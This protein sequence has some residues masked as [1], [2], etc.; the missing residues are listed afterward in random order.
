MVRKPPTV[1]VKEKKE[2][3]S[4]QATEEA[5]EGLCLLQLL[6]F[7]A[8]LVVVDGLVELAVVDNSSCG[9]YFSCRVLLL[10][11]TL[12]SAL[13]VLVGAACL[14]LLCLN[15]RELLSLLLLVV[16]GIW[17]WDYCVFE[18]QLLSCVSTGSWF[19]ACYNVC[20]LEV[21]VWDLRFGVSSLLAEVVL[22]A[23]VGRSCFL[24]AFAWD[25][26]MWLWWFLACLCVCSTP[27]WNDY[28]CCSIKH[29]LGEHLGHLLEIPA[30][31]PKVIS[32]KKCW[33]PKGKSPL[34]TGALFLG[35]QGGLTWPWKNPFRTFH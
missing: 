5:A 32:H 8:A 15:K 9:W 31:A 4:I 29:L 21:G 26:L 34:P 24:Y 19:F 18:F 3:S 14:E 16:C 20:C 22:H 11:F 30:R 17:C 13:L 6:L 28:Q 23:Y 2:P 7:F 10:L 35:G 25:L 1:G 12:P 27:R 33:G